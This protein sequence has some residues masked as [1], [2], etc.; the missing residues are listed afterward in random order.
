MFD[1]FDFIRDI[2]QHLTFRKSIISAENK[3]IKNYIFLETKNLAELFTL[4]HKTTRDLRL[5]SL[6]YSIIHRFVSCNH[7]LSL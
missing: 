2:Y 5:I 3:W 4:L 7:N 6:Q 1:L